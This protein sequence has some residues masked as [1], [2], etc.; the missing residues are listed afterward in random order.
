LKNKEE[1]KKPLV[2]RSC[3]NFGLPP[4]KPPMDKDEDVSYEEDEEDGEEAEEEEQKFSTPFRDNN[5]FSGKPS[6]KSKSSDNK[7]TKKTLKNDK[8][9]GMEKTI[10][11]NKNV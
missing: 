5:G 4:I 3:L 8:N 1:E 6:G 9:S 10:V 7:K 2:L 11:V